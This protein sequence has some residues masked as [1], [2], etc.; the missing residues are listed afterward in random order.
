[1]WP[2]RGGGLRYR[3]GRDLLLMVGNDAVP[4]LP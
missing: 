3:A 2:A 1:M 4:A